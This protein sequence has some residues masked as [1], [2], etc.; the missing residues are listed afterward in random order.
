MKIIVDTATLYSPQEGA[1]L[2]LTVVPVSVAIDGQ[3]YRDYTDLSTEAFL[4]KIAAGGVPTSSQPSVGEILEALGDGSE[5]TLILTVGAGLSGGYQTAVAAG[6]QLE[7][8]RRIHVLDSQTLAGPL[9]YL[10]RKACRL[11]EQGL[12]L[13]EMLPQLQQSIESSVSF[14]IPADF[15]FLKRSG[16]LTPFAAQLGS[17]LRLLPILTQTQD[18]T[19]IAPVTVKRSWNAAADAIIQRLQ[20]LPIDRDHLLTV[21]HAGV[22]E[23]AAAVRTRLQAVFGDTETELLELCPALITHGGPGCITVQAVLK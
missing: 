20:A 9:R 11:R 12:G 6:A 4:Q 2:G 5:E 22:P 21:C 13:A 3:T 10:A 17:A 16:R 23:R 7:G 18:R 1:A 14:V 19:H 15:S 8:A